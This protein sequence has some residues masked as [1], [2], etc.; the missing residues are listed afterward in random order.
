MA[1]DSCRLGAEP[2]TNKISCLKYNPYFGTREYNGRYTTPYPLF[3]P[4]KL[5]QDIAIYGDKFEGQAYFFGTKRTLFKH[6]PL[7]KFWSG[8]KWIYSDAKFATYIEKLLDNGFFESVLM[9]VIGDPNRPSNHPDAMK[10]IVGEDGVKRKE[11]V[12]TEGQMFNDMMS[13]NFS[14]VEKAGKV[15]AFWSLNKDQ[16]IS[17]EAFPTNVSPDLVSG[18]LLETIRMIAISTEVPAILANLPNSLSSLASGGDALKNAVEFMQANTAPKRAQLEKFYNNV[19]IP[20]LE[21]KTKATVKIQ[22]YS[23]VTTT[24]TVDDKFWDVLS[25]QQKKEFVKQNIPGIPDDVTII[26]EETLSPATLEAQASLRGSVGGVTGILSIQ[27]GVVAKTTTRESALSILTLV[28]GFSLSEA[29]SLLGVPANEQGVP[30]TNPVVPNIQ[31]EETELPEIQINDNLKNMTGRQ[32]QQFLRIIKQFGQGKLTTE[33]ATVML[34][35]G[36]GLSDEEITS[37]LSIE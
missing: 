8:K 25:P 4:A 15:M 18:A 21:T 3:D 24:V 30:I 1:L 34:K 11:S 6:Y 26:K 12:K 37:I 13:K 31:E 9:K 16:S 23:P 32:Q 7:P 33:Q 20:N 36:F 22:Q 2:D 27:Q 17:L 14:G 35:S 29:Y 10:E 5:K 19:L 28:Y